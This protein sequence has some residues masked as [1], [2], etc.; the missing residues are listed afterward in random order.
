MLGG[1]TFAF[2]QACKWANYRYQFDRPIGEFD[3]IQEK[4][5]RMGARLYAMDAILY[6]TTGFLDRHDDDIMLE[7]A[8]CKVFCSEMGYRIVDD[9]MQIMGGESYM[10]E[11]GIERIWRD[12][13]INIIVE[14]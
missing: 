10:T 3:L 6:M 11:N 1:A 13:R 8:M 9:T 12:S 4:I 7:T 5:A 2:E 14:G